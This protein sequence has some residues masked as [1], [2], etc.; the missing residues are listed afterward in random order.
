[1]RG[2]ATRAEEAPQALSAGAIPLVDWDPSPAMAELYEGLPVVRVRDWR[3][4][5]PA[6]LEG[7]KRRIASDPSVDLKKLY[8]PYWIARY[9]EHVEEPPR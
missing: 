5:T 6:F 3:A 7:E 8:L 4:V 9:T 1:M 2:A